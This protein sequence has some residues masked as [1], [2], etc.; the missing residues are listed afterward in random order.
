VNVACVTERDLETATMRR[1]T[2]TGG[3][4]AMREKVIC[5]GL[6]IRK[7]DVWVE[8]VKR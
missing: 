5:R 1:L 6:L 2:S 3:C 8:K 4:C 7:E